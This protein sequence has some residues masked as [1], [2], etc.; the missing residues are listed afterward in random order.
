MPIQPFRELAAR[1]IDRFRRDQLSAELGE[2]LDLHRQLLARDYEAG[3]NDARDA[4]G[5][6]RRALGNITHIKEETRDMWSLGSLEDALKDLRYVSR[7]IRAAPAFSAAVTI[8]LALGVGATTAMY[9]VADTVLLRPLPYPAPDGLVQVVNTQGAR[10][11]PTSYPDYLDWRD[12]TKDVLSDVITW[13]GSGEVLQDRG[14]AEQLQGAHV[15]ANLPAVLG[16]R[17]VTGRVFT[18]GEE[19]ADAPRVVMLGEAFWRHH[20]NA[21]RSMLGRAITLTG[22]PYVVIGIVP[23][24]GVAAL[25]S[26]GQ[27]ARGR[28]PDFWLPLRLDEKNAP[29]SMHWLDA[30]GRLRPGVTVEKARAR[31]AA[32][33]KDLQR[34]R[35]TRLGIDIHPLAP[36]ILGHLRAP[37]EL[38]LAAAALLLLIACTNVANLMLARA[39]SRRREFAV[40]TALGA[41]RQ[42]LL[43]LVLAESVMRALIG[44]ACG[45]GLAYAAVWAAR[46]GLGKT[47]PRMADVSVDGRVLGFSLLVSLVCGLA[48][49]VAPALRM[50][51]GRVTSDLR[52]GGRG[53]AGSVSRDR[54]RAT[55]IVG[56]IALSFMLLAGGG[57]LVRSFQNLLAVPRGF[58][59]TN[60]VAGSTW[61]P[62]SRYPD[63]IAVAGFYERVTRRMAATFGGDKVTVASDLPISGGTYGGFAVEGKEYTREMMPTAV[64]R[65]VGANYFDVLGARLVSGRFFTSADELRAPAVVVVNETLARSMFPGVNAIG[66]RVSFNWGI[67]GFQTIVG[68]VADLHEGALNE[69]NLPAIYISSTQRPNSSMNFIIRTTQPVGTVTSALRGAFNEA[70]AAVP[71]VNIETIQDVAFANVRQQALTMMILGAFAIAALLLASVGLYGV[72]SYSV[73]QRTQELGVRAALG[74][75]R[76]DLVRLVLAQTARYAVAGVA[77][78]SLGVLGAQKVVARQLFGVSPTDATTFV[79]AGCVLT[80]A[81]LIASAVPT[82]RASNADPL[83][84]LRAD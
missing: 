44:G 13:F 76:S 84:A 6:A 83:Q 57:L 81:A 1:I 78:G 22:F 29:R 61:L 17:P 39:A 33:A 69:P 49:G 30:V 38:L 16:I 21:D 19:G 74:A 62:S 46:S 20:F 43:R 35:D 36:A 4:A 41:S 80:V 75:Q 10:D 24:T 28:T 25:P 40:R 60:L 58:D 56:E 27:L 31:I 64:K 5:R 45:V 68:V 52:D 18:E 82:I 51:R 47:I 7:A 63:S 65:I 53:A 8:T 70:D 48:F 67:A 2:E 77:F 55:L 79:L 15:S 73:A 11:I 23:S 3:G 71:L 66:R 14:E 72:V 50:A 32:V 42:R 54:L 59:S 37:L 34:D 12:R 26:A 9:S